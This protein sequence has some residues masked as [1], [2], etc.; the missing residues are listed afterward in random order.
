V[1]VLDTAPVLPIAKPAKSS[2]ADNVIFARCGARPRIGHRAA[3]RCCRCRA[4]GDIGVTLNAMD[5]RK[6]KAVGGG[7]TA[8][9]YSSYKEILH[10]RL[11]PADVRT[12]PCRQG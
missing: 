2:L 12:P 11:R 4:I 6:A 9:Y 5:M 10:G 1:I 8:S 7:G 3:L